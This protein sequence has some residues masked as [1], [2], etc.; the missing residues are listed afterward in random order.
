[1]SHTKL[2]C[3]TQNVGVTYARFFCVFFYSYQSL[4]F[5]LDKKNNHFYY[6]FPTNRQL[7]KT[8]AGNR[9]KSPSMP[10]RPSSVAG[11]NSPDEK[12]KVTKA[13]CKSAQP[14][15]RGHQQTASEEKKGL[16]SA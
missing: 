16:I 12:G 13:R 6:Y 10:Q 9:N 15:N 4:S 11:I 14:M 1:M 8:T 3:V 5:F 7:L 2:G